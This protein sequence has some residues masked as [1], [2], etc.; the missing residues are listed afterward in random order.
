MSGREFTVIDVN[1]GEYPDLEQI[2]LHEEWAD[3]LMYCDME[4]FAIMEDGNLILMDECGKYV[5]CPTGRFEVK[6][7]E[8]DPDLTYKKKYEHCLK[9]VDALRGW[10]EQHYPYNVVFKTTD[11]KHN[12]ES[13][14]NMIY[15]LRRMKEEMENG[16][17]CIKKT[18]D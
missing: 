3:G 10:F 7:A 6:F 13:K 5:F 1:T 17:D 11:Q 9:I 14:N 4:G 18:D 8:G 16:N 15:F 12:P 2:A